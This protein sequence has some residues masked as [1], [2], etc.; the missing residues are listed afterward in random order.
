MKTAPSGEIGNVAVGNLLRSANNGLGE[1]R[2]GN[3]H[4]TEESG[5]FGGSGWQPREESAECLRFAFPILGFSDLPSWLQSYLH[6]FGLRD[7][8][9]HTV[10]GDLNRENGGTTPRNVGFTVT[11]DAELTVGTGLNLRWWMG[12]N[13][14]SPEWEVGECHREKSSVEPQ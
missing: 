13:I 3:L 5:E 4:R 11:R 9:N 7:R 6:P 10:G 12:I 14:D 8:G 2:G 1:Y